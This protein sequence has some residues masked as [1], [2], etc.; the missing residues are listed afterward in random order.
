M[1]FAY[2]LEPCT[3]E[4]DLSYTVE[5]PHKNQME[6]GIREQKVQPKTLLF[7][8]P[9]VEPGALGPNLDLSTGEDR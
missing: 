3:S 6:E 8:N 2:Y 5:F 9:A 1:N 7:P 4:S